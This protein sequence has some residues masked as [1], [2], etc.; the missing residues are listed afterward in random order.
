M[1]KATDWGISSNATAAARVGAFRLLDYF[2]SE[3]GNKVQN[4]GTPD[5]WV[6]DQV[7]VNPTDGVEGPLFS[8]WTKDKAAAVTNGDISSFLRDHIGAQIPIGY[9]KVIGFE[10]QST[11]ANGMWSW[12]P[13]YGA[14]GGEGV[15]MNSYSDPET[16]YQLV[17]PVFSLTSNENNLIQTTTTMASDIQLT[18]RLFAFLGSKTG[19]GIPQTQAQVRQMFVEAGVAGCIVI[20][21]IAY[22]RM[23][24]QD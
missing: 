8:Q 11:S 4:Y 10:L 19:E 13:Y 15:K 1:S 9:Q 6:T 5:L 21:R 7:Y 22:D 20:Y 3:E 24:T 23:K 14:N 12:D 17:P 16:Y 2:F 18:D